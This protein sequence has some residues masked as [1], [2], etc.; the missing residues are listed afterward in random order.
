MGSVVRTYRQGARADATARTRRRIL[1]AVGDLAEERRSLEI[2]LADVARRAE[3]SVQTVLRHFGT[4]DALFLAARDHRLDAAR[5]ERAATPGDV[6]GAVTALVDFYEHHGDWSLHMISR[7]HTDPVVADVVGRGR[8]LHREWV[9]E[10]FAP[11]LSDDDGTR[12]DLLVVSTDV[13]VW[14]V[15]R[16][17]MGHDPATTGARMLALVRGVLP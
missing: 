4:K 1:D 15:L 17:E 6:E 8:V 13:H 3:V 7:E 2:V 11:A 16:R 9:A 12:L 14:K 10:V 5:A